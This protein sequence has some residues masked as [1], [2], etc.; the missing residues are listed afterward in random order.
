VSAWCPRCDAVRPGATTCPVCGTPLATL[1]APKPA[2]AEPDAPPE[3]GQAVQIRPPAPSRLRVALLAAVLVLGGLAFV[4]GRSGARQAPAAA[5][6]TTT[7]ATATTADPG[8]DL[9][10]LGWR[11]RARNGVT[12][13]AVSIRRLVARDREAAAELTLRVDGLQPGQQLFALAGLRLIDLGGGVFSSPAA[14]EPM[15]I[16]NQAATPVGVTGDAATYT[17]FTAPAPRLESLAKIEVGGLI[18]VRPPTRTLELDTGGPWPAAPPLR[19]VS[20]GPRDTIMVPDPN[21]PRTDRRELGVHLAGVLVGAGRAVVTLDAR[22]AFGDVPAQALP[23]SAELRSGG[24]VLCRRTVVL[25][26]GET[27]TTEGLVLACKTRPV[28]RLTV[29]VGAGVKA[30]RLGATLQQ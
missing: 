29:A 19:A 1:E 4:A 5:P 14:E 26:I 2:A 25:R 9:R 23:L 30:L 11:G 17:V 12:V 18:V 7:A 24:Q 6:A 20:P 8:A 15:P 13:T 3:G 28:P 16:G 10:K 27:P 22:E 21:W